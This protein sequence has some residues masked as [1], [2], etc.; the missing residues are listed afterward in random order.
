MNTNSFDNPFIENIISE[1]DENKKEEIINQLKQHLYELENSNIIVE[2]LSNKFTS[3]QKEFKSLFLSKK[4]IESDLNS[5]INNL[6]S[7]N[8]ILNNKYISTKNQ[9]KTLISNYSKE[10]NELNNINETIKHENE[11]LKKENKNL[12]QQI[13]SFKNIENE[14]IYYKEK[15]EETNKSILKLNNYIKEL[16]KLEIKF[17]FSS[18]IFFNLIIIS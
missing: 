2:E 16:Y 7:E 10:I 6:L 14:V 3:L 5:K 9:I 1:S 17:S 12:I 8:E 18:I 4:Q 15:F 11:Y 13:S